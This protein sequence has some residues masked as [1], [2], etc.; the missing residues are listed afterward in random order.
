MAA[1][2]VYSVG[3]SPPA[4][5]ATLGALQLMQQEPEH[6]T[7]LNANS[8]LLLRL[9]KEAGFDTGTSGGH[10]IIPVITGSS[11]V[12][13]RLAQAIYEHGINVLP[14]I[15]PAV[16]EQAARLR[17][18]VSASH[19]PAQLEETVDKLKSCWLNITSELV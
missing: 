4:A 11:L 2:F 10:G 14:I 1:G 8:S 13:A 15:H 12:A 7:R 9:L 18:F 16:P 19:T 6:L 5:A 3:I 17:F